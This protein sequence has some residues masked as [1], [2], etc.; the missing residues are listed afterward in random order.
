MIC[1]HLREE[2]M[3]SVQK[4]Y[5]NSN[6]LKIKVYICKPNCGNSSVGRASASQA[7]GREF[8]PRLPLI[9]KTK[10]NIKLKKPLTVEVRGFC[11][12][13]VERFN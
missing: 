11:Y 2:L 7:E 9:R 8:E 4:R 5:K 1:A 13:G 6:Y 3:T 12:K 10:T